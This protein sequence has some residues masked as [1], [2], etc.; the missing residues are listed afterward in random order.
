M[1]CREFEDHM[2]SEFASVDAVEWK[3]RISREDWSG[4]APSDYVA[5]L[6]ACDD[7][8]TSLYSFLYVPNFDYLAH[9]CFHVAYCAANTPAQ[10]IDASHNR[11]LP[12]VWHP[13]ANFGRTDVRRDPP[14]TG[15]RLKFRAIDG[16]TGK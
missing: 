9:P 7:C 2:R 15:P 8:R 13:T 12:L 14:G 6:A 11:V 4:L 16:V 10:C 3:R 1:T 5:H